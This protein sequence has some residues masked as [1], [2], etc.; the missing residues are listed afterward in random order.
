MKTLQDYANHYAELRMH[1]GWADYVKDRVQELSRQPG[2]EELTKF[3]NQRVKEVLSNK[4][5][6]ST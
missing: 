6:G 1:P 2:F 5:Y 3:Y 4:P